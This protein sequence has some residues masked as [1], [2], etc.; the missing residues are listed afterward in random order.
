M[1]ERCEDS[2]SIADVGICEDFI[3]QVLRFTLYAVNTVRNCGAP[4]KL[5][6]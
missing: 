1:G 4:L 6:I 2:A 3:Q 5:R